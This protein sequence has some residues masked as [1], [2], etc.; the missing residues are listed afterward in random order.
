MKAYNEITPPSREQIDIVKANLLD[1]M[2]ER[3]SRG[4]SLDVTGLLAQSNGFGDESVWQAFY[5]LFSEGL[6]MFALTA[7]GFRF[8][9]CGEM[10][11]TEIKQHFGHAYIFRDKL[12]GLPRD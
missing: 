1:A 12:F 4:H 11:E 3:N 5:D 10:Y 7:S 9:R 8:S 6:C 2:R